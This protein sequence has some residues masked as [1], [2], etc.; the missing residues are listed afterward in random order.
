MVV[1]RGRY[2]RDIQFETSVFGTIRVTPQPSG[3]VY[4]ATRVTDFNTYSEHDDLKTAMA[5]IEALYALEEGA[6]G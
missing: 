6:S 3:L 5:Y 4:V 1:A 2:T